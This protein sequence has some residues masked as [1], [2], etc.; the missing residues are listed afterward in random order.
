M[1]EIDLSARGRARADAQGR[2][3]GAGSEQIGCRNPPAQLPVLEGFWLLLNR[4]QSLHFFG[5]VPERRPW[6]YKREDR[7]AV[8]A[9]RSKLVKPVQPHWFFSSSKMF[10]ASARSRYNCAT[11]STSSASEVTSTVY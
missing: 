1:I 8:F 7:P 11:A 2:C 5:E 10:S 4:S 9:G 6:A 3:D